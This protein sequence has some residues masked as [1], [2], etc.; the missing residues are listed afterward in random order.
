MFVGSNLSWQGT[1]KRHC[2]LE[3]QAQN[4]NVRGSVH[5]KEEYRVGEW[6]LGVQK[7]FN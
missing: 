3:G 6:T 1:K 2:T 4:V 5:C 7:F